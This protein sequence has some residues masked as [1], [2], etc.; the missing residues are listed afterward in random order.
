MAITYATMIAVIETVRELGEAPSGP[1]YA[2]LMAKVPILTFGDYQE[3]IAALK[4]TK[5]VVEKNNVLVWVGPHK[6]AVS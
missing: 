2:A 3:M 5:L 6:G 4:R 1:L